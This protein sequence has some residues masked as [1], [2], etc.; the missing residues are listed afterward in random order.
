MPVQSITLRHVLAFGSERRLPAHVN[1]RSGRL[2]S[3]RVKRPLRISDMLRAA[4]VLRLLPAAED[5]CCA[6]GTSG[7]KRLSPVG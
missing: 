2:R 5:D 4:A 1:R 7:L 3:R 6:A